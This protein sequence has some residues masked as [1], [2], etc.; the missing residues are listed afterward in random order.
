MVTHEP[1]D[2]VRRPRGVVVAGAGFGG[3]RPV[4]G[5]VGHVVLAGSEEHLDDVAGP[6]VLVVLGEGE[7]VTHGEQV[8]QG[9][10]PA[11]IARAGPL[12]NGGGGI[13]V[14]A[15][16]VDQHADHDAEHRLGHRPAEQR[17]LGGHGSR[18]G[19]EGPEGT[20]VPLGHDSAPVDDHHG[21]GG[22]E[23][24]IVV[25]GR[26]EQHGQVHR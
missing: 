15:T 3:Q 10:G 22:G 9:D 12:G 24:A 16:L 25:D 26:V 18:L 13:E 8:P 6:G 5:K 11:R 7:P 1:R 20:V 21:V 19:D 17:H 4:G 14:E 2:D 23:R